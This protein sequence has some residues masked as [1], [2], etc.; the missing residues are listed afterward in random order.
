MTQS[1]GRK[2][3]EPQTSAGASRPRHLPWGAFGIA[4]ALALS[5]EPVAAQPGAAEAARATRPGPASFG[6]TEAGFV[7]TFEG[8]G[9]AR[10][11]VRQEG[12]DLL[13]SFPGALPRLDAAALQERAADWAEGVNTGYDTLLLQLAPGVTASRIDGGDPR[14]LRILLAREA[15]AGPTGDEP[16]P[17]ATRQ[18]EFRLQ[19]LE[20]QLLVLSGRLTEARERYRALRAEAPDR[21]EPLAGLASLEHQAGRWRRSLDLYRE[22]VLLD[23]TD[24]SLASSLASVER[25]RAPRLR[26]DVE[27]RHLEGGVSTAKADTTLG[28]VGGFQ[29]FGDGW[30]L[31]FAYGLAHVSATQ[32]RRATGVVQR[33]SDERQRFEVFAQYDAPGGA[34]VI[35][36][37]FATQFAPGVGI[38]AQLPDDTGFTTLRAEYRRPNWDFV[39]SIVESGTRD[40]I[41]VGR[42]QR[43][44]PGFTGRL[45][46]GFNRYGIPDDDD[47][48]RSWSVTGE[49]RVNDVGFKGVTLAYGLDGEY[50]SHRDRRTGTQGEVFSPLPVLDRE[51]HLATVGYVGTLG[52]GPDTGRL[53]Y[54]AYGG[55]GVDRYGRSGPLVSGTLG[56]VLGSLEIQF[57][58]GY[59]ENIGRT[60][61]TSTTVGGALTW[62][63]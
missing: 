41:A 22:A 31:G 3:L 57:R 12:R 62:V 9:A 6:P 45:E 33:F 30:R 49:L 15:G 46:V 39:E 53:V 42:F 20:A 17:E 10:A 56:Y 25:E 16:S 58:V 8:P 51:V 29:K 5:P 21:V 48:V 50:V 4:A 1:A 47:V 36:S 40:R 11:T 24:L 52:S 34:T 13:I 54:Q 35:G 37:V 38:R 7:I 55:Y 28:E 26:T 19:V 18:G 44:L 14:R 43:F 61:G 23:P 59:V 2:S 63:F 60:R 27:Y 32:V